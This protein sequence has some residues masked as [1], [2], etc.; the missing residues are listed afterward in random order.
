MATALNLNSGMDDLRSE[1]IIE[2][3][4]LGKG[5]SGNGGGRERWCGCTCPS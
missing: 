4:V 2:L 3:G 1:E 5:A